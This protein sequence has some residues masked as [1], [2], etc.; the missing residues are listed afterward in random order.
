MSQL[1]KL[2][3]FIDDKITQ[4][5]TDFCWYIE[6]K[7][8]KNNLWIAKKSFLFIIFFAFFVSFIINYTEDAKQVIVKQ[9]ISFLAGEFITF[10]IVFGLLYICID[11]L[12]VYVFKIFPAMKHLE[13]NARRSP[14]SNKRNDAVIFCKVLL[15][16]SI[17]FVKEITMVLDILLPFIERHPGEE[18]FDRILFFSL[19]IPLYFLCTEPAPKNIIKDKEEDKVKKFG[20]QYIPQKN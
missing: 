7:F 20:F 10:I 4:K 2:Y 14:N 16:V 6:V 17:L 9:D 1:S 19:L 18:I 15:A 5:L 3:W 12:W 11:K 8:D 13:S